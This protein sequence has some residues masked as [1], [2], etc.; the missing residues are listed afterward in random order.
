[1]LL[2]DSKLADFD[3]E[4]FVGTHEDIDGPQWHVALNRAEMTSRFAVNLEGLS[5]GGTW[6][7]ARFLQHEA[8]DP[9]FLSIVAR[10][11]R[12]ES[13]LVHI[14]RDTWKGAR[15]R[16]AADNWNV[17]RARPLTELKA[18]TWRDA[19]AEAQ[20]CLAAPSGGRG[21]ASLIRISTGVRERLETTPHF[22]VGVTLQNRASLT[23]R[24][25]EM[26]QAMQRLA[27]VREFVASRCV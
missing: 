13:V 5:Y 20:R 17:L 18:T 23:E 3:D 8:D 12:P 6:P 24:A 10:V 27:P 4:R 21:V 16:V 11:E 1:M 26:R 15:T 25:M 7:I 22:S 9:G 14:V 2:P 19:V